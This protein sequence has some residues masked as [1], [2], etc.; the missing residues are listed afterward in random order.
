MGVLFGDGV[1]VVL[2]TVLDQRHGR[3]P[4]SPEMT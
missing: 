3:D 1:L 2:L 4:R